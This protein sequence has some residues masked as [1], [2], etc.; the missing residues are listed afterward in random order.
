[1]EDEHK[2]SR[3][4]FRRKLEELVLEARPDIELYEH[5]LSMKLKR[6]EEMIFGTR[7]G[8]DS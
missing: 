3:E 1:M 2:I 5:Q 4:E 6:L 8:F 7:S